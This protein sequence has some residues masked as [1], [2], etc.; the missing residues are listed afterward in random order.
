SPSPTPV[1][2]S[3]NSNTNSNSNTTTTTTTTTTTN[4]LYQSNQHI[5][6]I[7]SS[8]QP[9]QPRRS[10][11]FNHQNQINQSIDFDETILRTLCSL[12]CG[13]PLLLDRLKQAVGTSR[14]VSTFLK[15]RSQLEEEY[16]NKL[17]KLTRDRLESY[18]NL[19]GELKSGSFSK[20]FLSFLNAHERM[21]IERNDHSLRLN[22]I[23]DELMS[24]SKEVER[25]RKLNKD[26]G[27]RLEKTVGEKE[28][29]TEK[30]KNK[31][32]NT[33]E[34]LERVL[35]SKH[36]EQTAVPNQSYQTKVLGIPISKLTTKASKSANQI[37]KLEEELRNKMNQVSDFYRNQV[38]ATQQVRQEYFNLQLPRILRTLKEHSDE[39][40]LAI[41]Y[42]LTNYATLSESLLVNEA[43]SVSSISNDSI[44]LLPK[45]SSGPRNPSMTNTIPTA[46]QPQQQPQ[47]LNRSLGGLK[48]LIQD[49]DNRGDFKEYMANYAAHFNQTHHNQLNQNSSSLKPTTNLL[50]SNPQYYPQNS[51]QLALINQS[52]NSIPI[53][54]FQNQQQQ[55]L[56]GFL[57][58]LRSSLGNPSPRTS[59]SSTLV[60]QP[61][62]LPNQT[63]LSLTSA[64]TSAPS[65]SMISNENSQNHNS[66]SQMMMMMTMIGKRT[67]GVDLA[68]QMI[69]DGVE[70]VPKILEKSVELIEKYGGLEVVGIYRISGTT[71]KIARLKQRFDQDADNFNMEINEEN[72]N[73][74]NDLSGCLKLWLRELPEPLMTWKLYSSFIEAAKIENDRLRHIRLH[75]RVNELPDPNYATLKFLMGHLDRVRRNEAINSMGA[76][77]L[78]VIFGPTLL[79]PPPPSQLPQIQSQS[80]SSSSSSRLSPIQLTASNSNPTSLSNNSPSSSSNHHPHHH[81]ASNGNGNN[82]PA[83]LAIDMAAQCKAIETI[84]EHYREIF[85]DEEEEDGREI[86]EKRDEED[87]KFV[88][89][90]KSRWSHQERRGVDEVLYIKENR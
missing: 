37:A 81:Q 40:D 15:K 62:S 11:S 45:P 72:F 32:E 34:D 75:E 86:E 33:A 88:K 67:F 61:S 41:Q 2:Q 52:Q 64:T 31:F 43:L 85:V 50:H 71:S 12:E 82:H 79:S 68:S 39:I 80:A 35:L 76:S 59:I 19:G 24:I 14:E 51:H 57:P 55:Q 3:N 7:T 1:L 90:Q 66:Q 77:N 70:N 49:I 21:A 25:I 48:E 65:N 78:S 44:E 38:L 9:I 26:L 53:N 87:E 58:N 69:R 10:S 8:S 54:P 29:Q 5:Q 13:L 46:S 60:T 89:K 84:L 74:L 56:S 36:G 73:E 23:G 47:Q 63:Q 4:N 28:I 6:S 30:A 16:S 22:T 83:I 42:Y 20:Q 27:F 18:N 17:L